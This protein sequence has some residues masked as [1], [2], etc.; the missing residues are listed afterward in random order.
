MLEQSVPR[1]SVS[2]ALEGDIDT[3]SVPAVSQP[4]F[5][6]LEHREC[7]ELQV[8][9]S[10][11]S[12]IDARGLSMMA[13]AQRVA[14]ENNCR[15]MWMDPSAPLLKMLSDTGMHEYLSIAVSS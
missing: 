7:S 6:L 3:A 5:D 11:V 9:C 14:D 13:R 10:R 8:D 12:L 15:L 4:L 1:W 2:F